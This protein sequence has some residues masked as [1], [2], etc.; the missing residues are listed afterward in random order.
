MYPVSCTAYGRNV[1][2]LNE[3]DHHILY[4]YIHVS[5]QVLSLKD[6]TLQLIHSRLEFERYN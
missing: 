2:K 5:D 4:W 6:C 1:L 3:K